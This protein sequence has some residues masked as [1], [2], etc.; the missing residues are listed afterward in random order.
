ME[1]VN[2]A[3]PKPSGSLVERKVGDFCQDM[4]VGCLSMYPCVNDDTN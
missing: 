4:I 2:R 1:T 3:F